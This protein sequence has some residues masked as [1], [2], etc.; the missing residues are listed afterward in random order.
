[1]NQ[2]YSRLNRD[3]SLNKTI[4]R[5]STV[6]TIK[7]VPNTKENN[8][9]IRG[10]VITKYYLKKKVCICFSDIGMARKIFVSICFM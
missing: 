5:G 2:S 1:M 8:N 7:P 4:T 9:D 6:R 3:E 10:L